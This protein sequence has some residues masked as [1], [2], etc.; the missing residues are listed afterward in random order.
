MKLRALECR[1]SLAQ[2]RRGFC[3]A[4]HR[5]RVLETWIGGGKA[6]SGEGGRKARRQRDRRRAVDIYIYI[7]IHCIYIYIYMYMYMYIYIYIYIG[8][9]GETRRGT[10][11]GR[12]TGRG[13]GAT[14]G[15]GQE[16]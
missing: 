9:P 13:A 15:W 16:G 3:A 8:R 10:E 4:A 7:Y 5:E 11:P 2:G 14:R 1:L 12:G 6:W